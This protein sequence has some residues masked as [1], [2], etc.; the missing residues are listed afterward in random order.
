[1]GQKVLH[2]ETV[3][4]TRGFKTL[5]HVGI[6]QGVIT[7]GLRGEVDIV[8]ETRLGKKSELV[9]TPG[10]ADQVL[11]GGRNEL[12]TNLLKT[13]NSLDT[14]VGVVEGNKGIRRVGL[15]IRLEDSH[16]QDTKQSKGEL[17]FER[18]DEEEEGKREGN[19]KKIT[20]EENGGKEGG[21]LVEVRSRPQPKK[22]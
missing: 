22:L 5:E 17:H 7:D 18:R 20:K 14:S 6:S 1:M 2:A 21:C 9:N 4:G 19:E 15:S 3:V 13:S 16:S 8:Q 10:V 12:V 11:G